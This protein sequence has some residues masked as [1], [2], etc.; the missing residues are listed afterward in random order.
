MEGNNALLCVCVCVELSVRVRM[1][2]RLGLK[3]ISYPL[4]RFCGLLVRLVTISNERNFDLLDSGSFNWKGGSK[5]GI[6]ATQICPWSIFVLEKYSLWRNKS[7]LLGLH[8][9]RPES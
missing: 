2:Q 8:R 3:V 5:I 9:E 1:Y 6:A 7:G 4:G